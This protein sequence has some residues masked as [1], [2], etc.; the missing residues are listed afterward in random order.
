MVRM[1]RGFNSANG[2][3]K[4]RNHTGCDVLLSTIEVLIDV[5]IKAEKIYLL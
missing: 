2:S 1:S 4:R 3:T 5:D